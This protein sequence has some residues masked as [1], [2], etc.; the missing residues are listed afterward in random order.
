[1]MLIL[2]FSSCSDSFLDRPPIDRVTTDNFYKTYDELR[3]GTSA[4]YNIVWFDYNERAGYSIGDIR[5]NNTLSKYF[6]PGYYRFTVNSLDPNIYEAWSALYKVVAQSNTIIRN[7]KDQATEVPENQKNAVIAECRFMR[8]TSYFYLVRAWGP[9]MIVEDNI[10]LVENPIIPLNPV[11]DVYKFIINDLT[12]ASN[13]LPETDDPGRVTKWSAK[14]ML[15]KVYLALSGYGS[16]DGTRNQSLLDSAMYYAGDVC[17]NSGMELMENYGDL[18]KYSHNVNRAGAN[19]HESLFSLL[20]VPLGVWGSQNAT[21]SDF[22]FSGDVVG[23]VSAWG[24]HRAS[25]DILNTYQDND[26]IRRNATYMT[27][28]THYDEIDQAKGGYTFSD[29]GTCP[30]KKYVPGGPDDNEG[31]VASMNSPL[32]TYLLR[33]ADVYLIYAEAALGNQASLT[34]GDAWEYFQKVR[35]RA[36]V[37]RKTDITF[38]DI[39]YERRI[40]LAMEG[41][42][43]Y[44]LVSWFYFKPNEILS[45][46]NSQERGAEYTHGKNA[47]GSVRVTITT[48]EVPPVQATANDIYFPYPESEMVQNHYF[49]EAPVPY[50]FAE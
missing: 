31:Q 38:D 14:G 21:L 22:A 16:T 6:N 9:V 15:A 24:S 43:W 33:L 36:G 2:G 13:Y 27:D 17:K 47:D 19:N 37:E 11:E 35:D 44:D 26:T 4:L 28:K 34:D 12:Y 30:L 25:Y 32:N 48:I 7:I 18:F 10:A 45:Y 46:L 29:T 3:V 1:M 40:E 50:Y 20:W 49:N 8:G 42:Y 39:M 5:A 23:G 41:Q